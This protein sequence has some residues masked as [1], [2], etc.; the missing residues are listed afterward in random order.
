[1]HYTH[2]TDFVARIRDLKWSK[3]TARELQ[4]VMILSGYAAR[5]FAESLRIALRLHPTSG[6]LAEVAAGE[7][8]TINLRFGDFARPG[9]H[10]DFLWHF[11]D[12]YH[13]VEKCPREVVEAGEQYATA[14][15]RLSDDVRA[16]SIFSREHELPDIF[17]EVLK[18]V[19]WSADGLAAYRYY[20]SRHILLDSQPG[21]HAELLDS[22]PVD[23]SVAPFYT[24]RLDLYRC[25]PKLF[26]K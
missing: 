4:S 14:V 22:F 6:E 21:G 24:A 2:Y 16:M 20:L 11:I 17:R 3:L 25:I 12:K 23:D 9:D 10:A 8:Q 5:E 18:V 7:I 13:L 1:M 26:S 19:D 15:R